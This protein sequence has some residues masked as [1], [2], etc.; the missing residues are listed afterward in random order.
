MAIFR[1]FKMATAA[2]LDFSNF[3]IFNGRT[4]LDVRNAS[5]CQIWSKSVKTRRRYGDFSIFQDGGRR[6][7]GFFFKFQLLTVRRLK[8]VEL[9][10]RAKFG[11]NR[12]NR[13]RDMAIFRFL[14]MAAAAILDFSNFNFL[15]VGRHNGAELRRLAKYGRNRQKRGRQMAIFRFFTTAAAAILDFSNFIF[16]TV[17]PLKR[18]KLHHHAKFR[19]NRSNCGRDMA[20]FQF[21]T[22]AAAA[23]LDF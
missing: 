10:R 14:K 6:H 18:A 21:F 8:R 1:F 22:T 15:T 4:A 13:S 3:K 2:I 23:I 11:Q 12:S 17:R 5:P 20:I 19:Q 7:L 16:L 9:C